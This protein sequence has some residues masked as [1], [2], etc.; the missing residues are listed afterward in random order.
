MQAREQLAQH[1]SGFDAQRREACIQKS[2]IQ[3]A[4]IGG[5]L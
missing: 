1:W 2:C 3:E 4:C 5:T